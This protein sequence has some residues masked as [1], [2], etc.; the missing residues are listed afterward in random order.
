MR[1]FLVV[2]TLFSLTLSLGFSAQPKTAPKA[3]PVTIEVAADRKDALYQRG[4]TVT[5]LIQLQPGSPISPTAEIEWTL[6]KDGV[7]PKRSGRVTLKDGRGSVTGSLNEPGFLQCKVDVKQGQAKVSALG[8]A[9]I[10]PTA[11]KPSMPLPADFDAFWAEKKKALAAIP[12]NARLT[13]VKSPR[14]SVETF[15]LQADCVGAP[16]SGYFAKPADA[17]PKSLPAVLLVHGAGVRSAGLPG[18]AGWAADGALALD[19]NAHG[20]PNG[21]DAAFYDALAQGELKEYRKAGR[22][23]RDTVYFL[24]MFQRLIRAIDFLAARPE[25]D[26][27]T[28]VVYGSSQGGFQALA[29][30]GLDARVSFFAAGVPAGCD[31]TGFKVGRINGWP[32]FVATGEAAPESVVTAVRYFD[33]VN[34]AAR[35]KVPGFFTVGFIDTTCPPTSVYAA[36]N[37][38]RSPKQIHHDVKA[39]HTNTPEASKAMR[40]AALAHIAK[41]RGTGRAVGSNSN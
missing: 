8:G 29:A 6:A 5:F 12:I 36:Y 26:G 39:G 37:A 23:S 9:G 1:T 10:E 24:G 33:A 2:C 4:E 14:A 35:A 3:P 18:P 21:R 17:K 30:A 7:E 13:P 22:E 38:L 20:I 34:F 19:I 28:L 11:I 40:E 32:K 41:M 31:H 16:V 25:W 15:D 27:R